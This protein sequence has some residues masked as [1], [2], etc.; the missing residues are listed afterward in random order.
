MGLWVVVGIWPSR[1]LNWGS[2]GG[3]VS[4]DPLTRSLASV[5]VWGLEILFVKDMVVVYFSLMN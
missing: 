3:G 1:G 4:R 2:G 5:Q